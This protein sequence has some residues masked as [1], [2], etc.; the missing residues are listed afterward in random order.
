[1]LQRNCVSNN[2]LNVRKHAESVQ[3]IGVHGRHDVQLLVR[4][5]AGGLWRFPLRFAASEPE[6]D[7]E[8]IVEAA[9]LGRD[10][11]VGFRLSSQ[12]RSVNDWRPQCKILK[13]APTRNIPQGNVCPSPM[14]APGTVQRV[15]R[16][17]K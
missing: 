10:A 16:S 9:G 3:I 15:L 7:D 14:Q 8:V 12:T 13:T 1:M 11:S 5:A 4:G 2:V 17:W 6:V